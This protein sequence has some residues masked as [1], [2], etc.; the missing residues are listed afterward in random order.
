M[1][2][3]SN[4]KTRGFGPRN[5]GSDSSLPSG[6]TLEVSTSAGTLRISMAE[7]FT[8]LIM[9]A[10]R[11]TRMR[12]ELPKVLHRV[13]G[14]PMVEWVV[15]A[16][17][18]AG[19]RAR[20]SAWCGPGD[21]VAEGLPDGR[22]ASPSR[23]RARAPGP[24]CSRR[25]PRSSR[26]A[27][28]VVVLSGDHPL[29]SAELL[30]G[31]LAAHAREGAAATILTT[32]GPRPDG[33]GRIVRDGDGAVERIVETKDPDG[34]PGGRAGDPRDQPRHLRVRAGRRCVSALD[35]VRRAGRRAL[36]D[37][38][39]PGVARARPGAS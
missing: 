30:T 2:S 21:G 34:R 38:R 22:R 18:E 24:R 17:R 7:P 25:A 26:P 37:R 4:G 31:L 11:G 12:S 32:D 9:A 28:P 3:A 16:A 35:A 8:V 13:C 19:A 33:Y 27:A 14:K 29:V 36:P 5:G 39:H 6:R 1:G 23:R 15:D 20:S 10:G